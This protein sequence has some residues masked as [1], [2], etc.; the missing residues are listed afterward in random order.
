MAGSSSELKTTLMDLSNAG[1]GTRIGMTIIGNGGSRG[2]VIIDVSL[3]IQI[4]AQ[5]RWMMELY[6][7]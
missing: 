7:K 3:L 6:E 2:L 5:S 4:I 1:S